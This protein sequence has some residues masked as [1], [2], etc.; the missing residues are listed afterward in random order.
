M[1]YVIKCDCCKRTT[2]DVDP[3]YSLEKRWNW[4]R[5]DSDSQGIYK[6]RLH[7]CQECFEGIPNLLKEK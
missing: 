6:T 2:P 4:F 7:L 5:Y 3:R 1:S